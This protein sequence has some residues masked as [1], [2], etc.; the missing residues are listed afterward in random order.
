M[1]LKNS[2]SFFPI[3]IGNRAF[4]FKRWTTKN[5]KNYLL[6]KMQ[7]QEGAKESE[8]LEA[9]F[10]S[11]IYS[12]CE[13]PE[14]V[15]KLSEAEK[16]YILV[17]LRKASIGDKFNA[18]YVCPHCNKRNNQEL[19][20]SKV[21]SFKP[22]NFGTIKKVIGGEEVEIEFFDNNNPEARKIVREEENIV[23]K[24]I[25]EFALAIKKVRIGEEVFEAFGIE[26]VNEFIESLPVTDFDDLL[27]Q[28]KEMRASCSTNAIKVKCKYCKEETE[29]SL[30]DSPDF[31]PW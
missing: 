30:G 1:K 31:L 29:I 16:E 11:L 3:E 9:I 21:I 12:N 7:I 5:E 10:E 26:E 18:K 15:E 13:T 14:E 2:E 25:K 8:Y 22:S 4:F 6:A 23:E 28:Y 27:S 17:Q 19:S 20:I 24:I